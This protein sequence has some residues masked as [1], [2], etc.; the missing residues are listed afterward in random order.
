MPL[1]KDNIEK[2]S[3]Y[4]DEALERSECAVL[5]KHL[6]TCEMCR[7]VLRATRT[8]KE[9]MQKSFSDVKAPAHLMKRIKADIREEARR[10][11]AR[12]R[13][14]FF[15]RFFA[16]GPAWAAV[17]LVLVLVAGTMYLRTEGI[18]APGGEKPT[19]VGLYL[20]DIAHDAYL[21][22]GLPDRPMEIES[23]SFEETERYLSEHVGFPVYAPHLDKAGF[24]MQGGRLWHTVARISSLIEYQ[25]AEGHKLSLFEIRRDRIGKKGGTR[26]EVDGFECYVGDAFG[27]NGV[28]WMQNEV[29]LGLVAD[30]PRDRLVELAH[31]A[32]TDLAR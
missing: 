8:G 28:V 26:V 22:A 7:E 30:L 9:L 4:V 11:E 10:E 19:T 5:E 29:A 31:A 2:I 6:E 1:C 16:P 24:A 32:A 15:R 14:P 18:I 25:D 23:S 12:E 21:V 13:V 20:Y 17:S 3:A 27:F